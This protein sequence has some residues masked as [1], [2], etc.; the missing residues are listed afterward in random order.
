MPTMNAAKSFIAT[1]SSVV[2]LKSRPIVAVHGTY[3]EATKINHEQNHIGAI[4]DYL[5]RID[6]GGLHRDT[7]ILRY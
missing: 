1:K 2:N 4:V 6:R 5:G 3:M 7:E